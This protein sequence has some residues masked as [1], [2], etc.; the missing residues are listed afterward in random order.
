MQTHA[1]AHMHTCN[2]RTNTER[3]SEMRI[4]AN[5]EVPNHTRLPQLTVAQCEAV[6]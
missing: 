4:D 5:V 1:H 2:K 3:L 6:K